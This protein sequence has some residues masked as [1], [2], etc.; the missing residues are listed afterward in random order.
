[1]RKIFEKIRSAVREDRYL[2]A[3][4]ADE[5]CEERGITVWQVV[6][7]LEE[8]ELLEERPQ[9]KPNP[10]VVVRQSLVDGTTVE[11]VWTWL[12]VSRRAKLVTVFFENYFNERTP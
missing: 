11:A 6:A 4:H 9:S 8:A 2:I 7:S 1:M 5:R 3:W 10:S 12:P